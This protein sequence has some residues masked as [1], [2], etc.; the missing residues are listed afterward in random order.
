MKALVIDA[1]VV[2]SALFGEEHAERA[3]RVLAGERELH[4]PDFI[5]TEIANVIWKRCEREEIDGTEAMELLADADRLPLIKTPANDLVHPALELAMRT[6]R[7]VYDC[8]YLALAVRQRAVMLTVDRRLVNA[9]SHSP[10]EKQIAW[11]GDDR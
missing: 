1:S 3:R 5:A 9:L 7:T 2:A 4:V 8:L 11:L 10:L 6:H